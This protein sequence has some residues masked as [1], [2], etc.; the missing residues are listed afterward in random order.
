MQAAVE[1][2]QPAEFYFTRLAYTQNNLYYGRGIGTMPIPSL[3]FT[4][5]ELGGRTFFPQQGWGWGIDY[6]GGDCKLMWGIHRLTNLK[7]HPNPNVIAAGDPDIFK[8]PFL[9]AV[10]PGAMYLSDQDARHL[11]DY[12]LRGGFLHVD[13]FWGLR[14]LGNFVTQMRKVFPDRQLEQLPL[15]HEV[16]H[17]FYDV[18]SVVQVPNRSN[19]CYD[20][21]TWEQPDDTVP[22]ILGMSDDSGRLMMVVTYNSDL[23]DAW[24]YMDLPCYP[25]KYSGAAYRMALNFMLYALT[26]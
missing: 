18:D 19:G 10:S 24:E 6:P 4:C 5:P 25:E 20:R 9:Y 11:R 12:L 7:V 16:F 2:R 8:F 1:D 15:S 13:D 22:R 17:T 3:Q 26:H 23:G 21:Q 14:Q